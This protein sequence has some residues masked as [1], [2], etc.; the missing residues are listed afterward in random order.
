V[1]KSFHHLI[2]PHSSSGSGASLISGG[3]ERSTI[4]KKIAHFT[5][6]WWHNFAKLSDNNYKY[7]A[8]IIYEMKKYRKK[9]V[10]QL[11]IVHF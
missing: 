5:N 7:S 1:F 2:P 3:N 8:C 6:I 10:V 9:S 11:L 4:G